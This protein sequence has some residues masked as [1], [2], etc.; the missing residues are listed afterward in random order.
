MSSSSKSALLGLLLAGC[1]IFT[2]GNEMHHSPPSQA[3]QTYLD[4]LVQPSE[5][6]MFAVGHR[7]YLG[8]VAEGSFR[9]WQN[10]SISENDYLRC[11]SVTKT[12]VTYTLLKSTHVSLQKTI[13]GF[14]FP[15]N[16]YEN[17]NQITVRDIL[18]HVSGISEYTCRLGFNE[19]TGEFIPAVYGGRTNI[20]LGWKN[21]PVDFA[22]RQHFSYSNTG[23]DLAGE[24]VEI[25]TNVN[26][27]IWI[28]RL[29]QKVAPSLHIDRGNLTAQDFPATPTYE[30]YMLPP[31][32]P[33]YAGSLL[34]K[35][36]DLIKGLNEIV[37]DRPIWRKMQQW[38]YPQI[39]LLDEAPPCVYRIGGDK[40]GL[41]LQYY[42]IGPNA[43]DFAL[44]HEG[45][46]GPR[47]AV[48]YQP[49]TENIFMLHSTSWQPNEV[50]V[51]WLKHLVRL[52]NNA[53]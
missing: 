14:G 48:I 18:S 11:G 44:G 36:K 31:D 40:Y 37:N 7:N 47:T 27:S 33:R 6:V 16:Q 13:K 9:I 24:L 26:A 41:G 35:P 20:D 15:Q 10:G 1:I 38:R 21:V 4:G 3:I 30:S 5:G 51:P 39:P 17:S 42:N 8:R 29:F 46:I 50:F 43:R 45:D 49:S 22:P 12:I 34:S 23:F 2:L 32:L 28:R 53:L 25:M 52:Y 19:T